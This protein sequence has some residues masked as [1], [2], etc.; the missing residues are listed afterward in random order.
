MNS[1]LY[2]GLPILSM[3]GT[4]INFNTGLLA[5]N[6]RTPASIG[7]VAPIGVQVY[8]HDGKNAGTMAMHPAP[9]GYYQTS[10]GQYAAVQVVEAMPMETRV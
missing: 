5:E 4:S 3:A 8:N 7:M 1:T 10:Q 6:G 2:G 9:N